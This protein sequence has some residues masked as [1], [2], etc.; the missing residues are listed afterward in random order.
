MQYKAKNTWKR[1]IPFW[2]G[3]KIGKAEYK[4]LNSGG[5]V[6]IK[7]SPPRQVLEFLDIIPKKSKP[8]KKK[9]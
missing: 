7:S 1:A 3:D 8:K 6:E 4:S 9:K 5:T 2:V